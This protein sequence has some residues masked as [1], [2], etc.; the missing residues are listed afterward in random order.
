MIV[1]SRNRGG[2]YILAEM[3]G[4]VLARP[5]GAFRIIPYFPRQTIALPPLEDLLDISTDELRRREQS[6]EPD[7]E[8]ADSVPAEDIEP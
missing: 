6:T 3:N 5:I 2:A 4:A 1:I 8:F 7:E